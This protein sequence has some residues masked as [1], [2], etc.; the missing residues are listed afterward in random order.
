[1]STHQDTIINCLINLKNIAPAGFVVGLHIQFTTSR[2]LFQTYPRRWVKHYSENG[3]IV[4]DPTVVWAAQNEGIKYWHALADQD[5]EG[6]LKASAAHGLTYGVTCA[7][8]DDT[9]RSMA[10]FAHDQSDF[11][12]KTA[13]S[14]LDA[15]ALL[16]D[17][18]KD[19][20]KLPTDL[21]SQLRD[22]G[23][24]IPAGS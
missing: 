22:A 14:L 21:I 7:H 11:D 15:V 6:V 24:D 8:A 5:T 20:Q 9:S 17:N 3:L 16:H 1:M 12:A 23:I 10:G 19:M 2:F 4:S 13:Q 18:T